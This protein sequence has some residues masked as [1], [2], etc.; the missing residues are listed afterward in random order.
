LFIGETKILV[1]FPLIKNSGLKFW[2][3]HMMNG[4]VFFGWLNQPV[5]GHHVPSFEQKYKQ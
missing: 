2:A 4:M 5:P 3:F 1:R